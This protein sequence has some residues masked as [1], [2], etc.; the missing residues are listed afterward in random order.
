MNVLKKSAKKAPQSKQKVYNG[1]LKAPPKNK[2]GQ[3][4]TAP[5]QQK[6]NQSTK[7]TIEEGSRAINNLDHTQRLQR[8]ESLILCIE[9]SSFFNTILSFPQNYELA[10]FFFYSVY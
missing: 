9:C 1:H 2:E 3:Q 5:P 7:S 10:Y 8:K 4:K 6:P